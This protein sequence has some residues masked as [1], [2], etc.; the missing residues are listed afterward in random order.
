MAW[1]GGPRRCPCDDAGA[2][3]TPPIYPPREF[4]MKEERR[5]CRRAAHPRQCRAHRRWPAFGVIGAW[6]WI[7]V[8]L[9]ATGTPR[10]PSLPLGLSTCAQS[11][12]R[13]TGD[14]RRPAPPREQS[15]HVSRSHRRL[16]RNRLNRLGAV[17]SLRAARQVM[18]GFN[19]LGR[20]ATAAGA[21]DARP[22]EL[23]ALALSV[24]ARCDPLH[25]L[26]RPGAGQA[27]RGGRRSTRCSA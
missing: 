8:V 16:P 5:F 23:I 15:S 9:L 19:D 11:P 17:K 12:G 20:A 3:R 24:A 26:S 10:L 27:R 13:A 25:R 2:V 7:G 21:L 22:R 1:V 14:A 4:E 6:G 18:K